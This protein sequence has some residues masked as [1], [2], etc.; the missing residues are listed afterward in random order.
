M[1]RLV[2][3]WVCS[4]IQTESKPRS[5]A[6][7]ARSTTGID[8]SVAKMVTPKRMVV[9]PVDRRPWAPVDRRACT[10]SLCPDLTGCQIL[11]HGY[12]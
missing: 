12:L 1:R 7:R 11:R 3:M 6:A 8:W 10:D 2:G 9:P 5:S 4:G